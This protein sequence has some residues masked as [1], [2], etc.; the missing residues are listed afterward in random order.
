MTVCQ[1]LKG[2]FFKKVIHKMRFSLKK[3]PVAIQNE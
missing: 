2:I 1:G 3:Q